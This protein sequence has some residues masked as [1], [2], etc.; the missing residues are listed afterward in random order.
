MAECLGRKSM[1][2]LAFAAVSLL[3]WAS[4]VQAA[5]DEYVY[6]ELGVAKDFPTAP[7][8]EMGTYKAPLAKEAPETIFSSAQGDVSF[9]M[10][11][12]DFSGRQ[13]DGGN[14]LGEA[15]SEL[16]KGDN[17]VTLLDFP[18]YDKGSNSV[19]GLMLSIDSAK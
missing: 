4:P 10:T 11:V 7:T 1:R 13:G 3:A 5:W 18:L 12:V 2:F 16:T 9:K 8:K 15:A 14:L 17:N 19:Y 6:P